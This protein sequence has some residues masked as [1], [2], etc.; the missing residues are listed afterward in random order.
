MKRCFHRVGRTFFGYVGWQFW[1]NIDASPR[2]G[3]AAAVH[4]TLV[5]KADWNQRGAGRSFL[6]RLRTRKR[7]RV[8]RLRDASTR[9]HRPATWQNASSKFVTSSHHDD[10]CSPSRFKTG[11]VSLGVD[12]RLTYRLEQQLE[13]DELI[14]T[15]LQDW[16]SRL[17]LLFSFDAAELPGYLSN[18]EIA[19]LEAFLES[20]TAPDLVERL[21]WTIS[22]S[23]PSGLT[24]EPF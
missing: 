7:R 3:S 10:A 11:G 18:R 5:M 19:D 16:Y 22:W 4:S 6:A 14:P 21:E 9:S 24:V 8:Q 15:V 17:L 2:S 13:Q 23:V 12:P 20:L 1:L